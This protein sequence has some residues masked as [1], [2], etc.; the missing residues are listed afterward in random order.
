[1]NPSQCVPSSK[2]RP[3]LRI[4]GTLDCPSVPSEAAFSSSP[5]R[6]DLGDIVFIDLASAPEGVVHGAHHLRT[7]EGGSRGSIG[8]ERSCRSSLIIV[9]IMRRPAS[10]T[11]TMSIATSPPR[12]FHSPTPH[13]A[14]THPPRPSA[15]WEGATGVSSRTPPPSL[16]CRAWRAPCPCTPPS[17]CSGTSAPGKPARRTHDA[18]ARS[19]R[20]GQEGQS[21]GANAT[22]S[23]T[24]TSV[25]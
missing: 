19:G 17:R 25:G 2:R 12:Y 16:A 8:H 7:E 9:S 5:R 3:H 4:L 24:R 20:T 11:T 23:P 13:H 15:S 21:H 22:P 18:C 6:K 10:T 1:V 14:R